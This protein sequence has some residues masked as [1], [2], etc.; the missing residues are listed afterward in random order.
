VTRELHPIDRRLAALQLELP[1][2]PA[3]AGRYLPA[4]RSGRLLFVS[5]QFPFVDGK[6]RHVGQI[7]RELT[8]DEGYDAARLAALNVLAQIRHATDAWRQFDGIVRLDGHLNCAA[9]FRALPAVLDGA[10]DL[11]SAVLQ[12]RAGHAR[13]VFGHAVLPL[14]SCIELVAIA[15]VRNSSHT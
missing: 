9:D 12:E 15:A 8:A 13:A 4:C 11:F 6:L 3:P 10:S 5:G 7:G 14:D 1:P 2:P